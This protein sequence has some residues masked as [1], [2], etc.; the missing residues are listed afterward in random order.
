MKKA[1]VL[2]ASGGMGSAI[3]RE[4]VSRGTQVRAFARNRDKLE[5]MFGTLDEVEIY[6]G[7]LFNEESLSQAAEGVE[8]IYHAA[9]IPYQDWA[10]KLPTLMNNILGTAKKHRAKLAIVDNIYAYGRSYGTLI[11]EQHP[12]DPHT[13]KGKLRLNV[14][15]LAKESGVSMFIAHFPDFYGPD[16]DNTLLHFL[17][18]SIVENK[19]AMFVGKQDIAREYIFT[20][21][22]AKAI[23]D[24]SLQ[25]DTY[26]ANWNVPGYG[27]ITGA[28]IVKIARETT[29]YEK[30][31]STVTKN[32]IRM[33]GLFNSGMR[34][35]VEMFYLNEEPVILSGEKYEQ[36]F[37]KWPR[38]SYEE[39]IKLTLEHLANRR[40]NT[41]S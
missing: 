16:A 7:D 38:T 8:I 27:V 11:T 32:M 29:G 21:D 3:V 28:E 41:K 39:G 40:D 19:K 10:T 15:Q 20:P 14:E 22:G 4:L 18:K 23:V 1:L 13:K 24:L 12:K 33:L 30:K 31:V 17:F 36:K 25:D 37:G 26:G 5:S 35:Y 6:S 2:G 34:E 9:N